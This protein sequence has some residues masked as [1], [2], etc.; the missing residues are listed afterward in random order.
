MPAASFLQ[1]RLAAVAAA[2]GSAGRLALLAALH[3]AA[4]GIMLWSEQELVT[5]AAFLLTWGLL[6]FFWLALLRRPLTAA[7]LSLA[8][9]AVLILLS[10]FKHRILMMT[11]TFVD[12]MIVDVDTFSFLLTM[13]PGLAWKVA[14]G[15][16]AGIA[17]LV[18][19]WLVEPFRVRRGVAFVGAVV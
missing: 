1:H 2:P 12:V 14:A 8:M 16:L 17:L 6:N 5:S 18:L 13:I 7:A 10:H 3:V 19:F 4:L 15:V 11:V 9:I